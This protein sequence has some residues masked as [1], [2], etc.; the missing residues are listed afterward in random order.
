MFSLIDGKNLFMDIVDEYSNEPIYS[1][2]Y[3][4]ENPKIS[5]IFN[6]TLVLSITCSKCGNNND[7]IFKEEESIDILKILG[8]IE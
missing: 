1:V 6:K 7:R 2:N 8:L 5:C 4:F 3:E